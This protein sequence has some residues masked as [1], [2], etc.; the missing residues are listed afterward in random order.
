MEEPS[1]KKRKHGIQQRQSAVL[2][3]ITFKSKFA[4]YLLEKMAWGILS[5]VQ[6]QEMSNL[7][8]EDLDTAGVSQ[9]SF[10]ELYDLA[11][12]GSFGK[13]TQNLHRDILATTK[14]RCTLKPFECH[15]PFKATVDTSHEQLAAINL[16]HE[17]FSHL[18]HNY[19]ESFKRH[20][21]PDPTALH[22]FWQEM[23]G[24]PGLDLIPASDMEDLEA[25]GIPL[26]L[27]G[28]EVPVTG[29]GKVWCKLALTFQFY[30]L[31]AASVGART[32]DLMLWIWAVFERLCTAGPEGTVET[33]M[34]IMKWSFGALYEGKWP[35]KDWRGY[36]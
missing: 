4:F 35:S 27:H 12:A 30:S 7:V 1:V 16:P 19:P 2:E 23:K 6:V 5:T 3:Q 21:L 34:L 22:R 28:D 32:L 17:Q 31:M 26:G 36:K 18:Y 25:K 10:P 14:S 9:N 13:H 11:K 8:R 20:V 33:F 24:H 29:V 15:L